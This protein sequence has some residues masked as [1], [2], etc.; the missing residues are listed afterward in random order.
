MPETYTGDEGD[1]ALAAGLD[2]MDG[3]EDASD[4]DAAINKTRDYVAA[5]QASIPAQLAGYLPTTEAAAAGVIAAGKLVRYK[6]NT[7]IPVS[8]PIAAEDAANKFYVDG[9]V[10]GI[11]LSSRVAKTGDTMTGDL[12]LPNATPASVATWTVAYIDGTGRVS[13]G[14]S[15]AKYKD[16]ITPIDPA[17]LGDLFPQLH[18][19]V[20][21]GD[22]SAVVHVGYIANQL[23]ESD[24]L[25]PFVAYRRDVDLDDDGQVIGS[26]LA[27]DD[28]GNPIPESIDF[29]SQLIAQVAQ[30][31]ATVEELRGER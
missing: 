2:V 13:R 31:H 22:P 6:A 18:T 24:A 10:S 30:L 17:S 1:A 3:G 11:D 23:N 14:A 5:T 15:A 9:Q 28:D 20:M 8:S 4:I 16:Q 26:H 29:I 27:R 7:R 21:K 12:Y 19:F 25:R